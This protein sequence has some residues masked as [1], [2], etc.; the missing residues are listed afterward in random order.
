M[1][2]TL[3]DINKNICSLQRNNIHYYFLIFQGR[4]FTLT[5][6]DSDATAVVLWGGGRGK[7]LL[8]YI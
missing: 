2:H 1:K 7:D 8:I 6:S 4:F 5:S 3:K